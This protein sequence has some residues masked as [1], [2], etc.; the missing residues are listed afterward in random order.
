MTCCCRG[1]W[2]AEI[3]S[4]GGAIRVPVHC[5]QQLYDVIDITDSRAG[6][7]AAKKRVLGIKLVYDTRKGIYEEQL[8]LGAP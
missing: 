7:N 8:L 6:L 3:E 4:V 2:Q 1:W 5:G